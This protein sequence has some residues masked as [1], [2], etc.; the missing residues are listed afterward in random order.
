MNLQV[1]GVYEIGGGGGG[2]GRGGTLS[3]GTLS[4]GML[5]CLGHKRGT[6][7]LYRDAV[8]LRV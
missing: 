7:F 5:V 4:K 2:G 1:W 3:R 6:P 8:G